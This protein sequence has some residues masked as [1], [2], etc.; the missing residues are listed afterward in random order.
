MIKN[1][2]LAAS[3]TVVLCTVGVAADALFGPNPTW[4]RIE[5]VLNFPG[6]IALAIAGPGHG[7]AQLV[8]PMLFTLA[9]YFAAFWWLLVAVRRGSRKKNA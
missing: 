4:T 1:P 5:Q 2:I 9:F 6:V 3:V 8:F 7:F